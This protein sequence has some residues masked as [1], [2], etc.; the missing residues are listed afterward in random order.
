MR[1]LVIVL[2]GGLLVAL[3]GASA[4]QVPDGPWMLGPRGMRRHP[5]MGSGCVTGAPT[6]LVTPEAAAGTNAGDLARGRSIYLA[7]CAACHNPDPSRDGPVGPAIEGSGRDLVMAR[8]LF[9][10]YPRGYTPK[11]PTWVMPAQP[12]LAPSIADLVAYLRGS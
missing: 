6:P 12:E 1:H 4:A 11:R 9:A 7:R 8:V 5:M 10:G 3:A 2:A